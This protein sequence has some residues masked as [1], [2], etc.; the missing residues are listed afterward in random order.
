M[1]HEQRIRNELDRIGC[2]AGVLCVLSGISETKLSRAFRGVQDLTGPE[3]EILTKVLSELDNLVQDASPYQ[4][5]FRNPQRIKSLLEQRRAGLRLVL[6]PLGP[7]HLC[8]QFESE[9]KNS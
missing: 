8:E 3:V 4:L 5:S 2:T 6:I 7:K 9:A 1:I